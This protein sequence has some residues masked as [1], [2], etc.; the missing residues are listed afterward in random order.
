MT[1]FRIWSRWEISLDITATRPLY[2]VISS[3]QTEYISWILRRRW[4]RRR[5]LR[6]S[7]T[8]AIDGTLERN[9][10]VYRCF[11]RRHYTASSAYQRACAGSLR[12]SAS[13]AIYSLYRHFDDYWRRTPPHATAI[14]I[15]GHFPSGHT[16]SNR[17][18]CRARFTIC[19]GAIFATARTLSRS[20]YNIR[21][22]APRYL[23][24]TSIL[25][26]RTRPAS[27]PHTSA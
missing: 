4:W 23:L 6:W 14:G 19:R 17:H 8:H 20:K 1:Y 11:L 26:G 5:A 18:E 22:C 7:G 10:D 16:I 13:V 3:F 21:Q 27:R 24:Q 12:H 15:N 9:N 2:T 25:A